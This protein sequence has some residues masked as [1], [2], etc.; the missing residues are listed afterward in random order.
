M[1]SSKLTNEYYDVVRVRI[2]G[3]GIGENA[4]F[5]IPLFVLF[6]ALGVTTDGEILRMI[7][8]DNDNDILKNK[9][10][11]ILYN[12]IKDSEPVYTQTEAYKF[13]SLQTKGKDNFNVLI[14]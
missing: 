11:D 9:L 4:N 7:I 8:Y 13:L 5:K 12:T 3:I 10:M 2:L 14:F 6:R 1:Q